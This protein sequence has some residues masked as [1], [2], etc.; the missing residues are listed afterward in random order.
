MILKTTL[1]IDVVFFGRLILDIRLKIFNECSFHCFFI[2]R[3][4]FATC[5]T[6]FNFTF[7]FTHEYSSLCKYHM[8]DSL[9]F[10]SI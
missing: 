10:S 6:S 8:H 4:F 5:I 2:I 1:L 3:D 9:L 7:V